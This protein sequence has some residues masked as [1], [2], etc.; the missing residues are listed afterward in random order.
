MNEAL[1]S[2][3]FVSLRVRESGSGATGGGRRSNH[4][5]S[6]S[7]SIAAAA[8]GDVC[9]MHYLRDGS[10]TSDNLPIL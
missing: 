7:M 10:P 1:H 6:S 8:G 4:T 3:L 9:Y 2:P 5:S